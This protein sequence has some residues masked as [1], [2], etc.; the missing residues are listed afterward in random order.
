MMPAIMGGRKCQCGKSKSTQL[1]FCPNC[2]GKLPR[3]MQQAMYRS[4]TSE[5]RE[6]AYRQCVELLSQ[7][8][9]EQEKKREA[10]GA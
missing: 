7:M 1:P 6:K 4:Q 10:L 2:Y 9:M 3:S 8:E 5:N